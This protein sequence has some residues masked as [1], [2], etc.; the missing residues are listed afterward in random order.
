MRAEAIVQHAAD[1][2]PNHD[3]VLGLYERIARATTNDLTLIDALRR[4]GAI[5]PHRV[6]ALREAV[7]LAETSLGDATVIQNLLQ[8]YLEYPDEQ[9]SDRVWAFAK[10]AD[11]I[12]QG[13]DFRKAALLKREAATVADPAQARELLLDVARIASGPLGDLALAEGIFEELLQ[14]DPSDR[15]TCERLG[16]LYRRTQALSKL[17][18]LLATLAARSSEQQERARL[19]VERIRILQ[20]KSPSAPRSHVADE[21]NDLLR[22]V[23]GHIEATL[24]LEALLRDDGASEDQRLAL[25]TA[26]LEAAKAQN[27]PDAVATL[28]LKLGTYIEPRDPEL[29]LATYRDAVVFDAANKVLLAA[30]EAI[31]A[32]EHRFAELASVMHQRLALCAGDEAESVALELNA[33]YTGLG[34]QSAALDALEIGHKAAPSSAPIRERLRAFFVANTSHD[35]LAELCLVEA[36]HAPTLEAKL[37][38][39]DE[40]ATLFMHAVKAP[41]RAADALRI[42]RGLDPS[43]INRLERLVQALCEAGGLQD[44]Y[45]ELTCIVQ[46]HENPQRPGESQAA[47][48]SIRGKAFALRASLQTRLG[49]PD[50]ARS[51][52]EAALALG[53]SSV[54]PAYASHLSVCARA[55]L[56]RGDHDEWISLCLQAAREL[57]L[58][59]QTE[60]ARARLIEVLRAQR[61]HCEAL[62]SL[63]ELEA[64]ESEWEAASAAY[65]RLITLESP[66]RIEETALKLAHACAQAGRFH[67]A[68]AGLERARALAPANAAVREQ[69]EAL[70]EQTGAYR[71]LAFL[72]LED[73]Q[74]ADGKD[75]IR[76]ERLVRAGRYL[77]LH[78]QAHDVEQLEADAQYTSIA[79]LEQ[80]S[81]LRP[82]DV[83]CNALLADAYASASRYD[84]A[85]RVLTNT[86]ALF[87]GRRARE[88]SPVYH[89]LARLAKALNDIDN[90]RQHLVSAL[91]MD[92]QNGAVASEL[93]YVAMETQRYDLAQRALRCVTMLKT[94]APLS[95]AIAYQCL[96]QI[97]LAQGDR[98]RA[99]MLIKRAIEEDPT[100]ES[101][102]ELL[103]E[104]QNT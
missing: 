68:R 90:E 56:E 24:M 102:R 58:T 60:Q 104:L 69:L 67:E 10:L 37:A 39:L 11:V 99:L 54:R 62:R 42:A 74:A 38:S 36:E 2:W 87:K 101:A 94:P 50:A 17:S 82:T 83:D 78:E 97:E 35:R 81:A 25:L 79:V 5:P 45:D 19:R 89:R 86:I 66:E 14:R 53:E 23:P 31:L 46:S 12:E 40:A 77:W 88:L 63:A 92:A 73:A 32:R 96:G 8:A 70:Y 84:D 75:D 33:L 93:A 47:P 3:R 30:M 6:R 91:D 21:L 103:S 72:T 20:A 29:A 27:H 43:N 55:A 100:L 85:Q 51:D 98:R 4:R 61:R 1:R 71:E 13:G 57:T 16:D 22:E 26:Q 76:F 95:K 48:D 49:K 65:R 9:A 59:G 34:N 64:L 28:S 18:E 80:A 52:L 7:A 15:E 41:H 44:A